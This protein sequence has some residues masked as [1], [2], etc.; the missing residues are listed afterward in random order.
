[1]RKPS[2]KGSFLTLT[3][4]EVDRLLE[5]MV[6]LP[7]RSRDFD[8]VLELY[9][10]LF[11]NQP[12]VTTIDMQ[13]FARLAKL[14]RLFEIFLP[15]LSLL[16]RDFETILA[17]RSGDKIIG[18][19]HVVP[20]GKNVWSLD[21]SVVDVKFRR[22]GVYSKLLNESLRYISERHGEQVNTSLWTTNAA[23]L[24]M[25]VRLGFKV[26]ETQILLGRENGELPSVELDKDVSI[27]GAKSSDVKEIYQIIK[28]LSPVKIR[29]YRLRP[30][31]FRDSFLSRAMSMI[32]WSR[33]E[34]WVM[35]VNG[36]ITG[37]AHAIFTSPEQTGRIESLYVHPSDRSSQLTNML[38]SEVL[39]FLAEKNVRRLLVSINIEWKETIESLERFGF[40]PIASV[41]EMTKRLK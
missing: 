23:P 11:K 39:R 36:K 24:K 15:L 19:I 22:R 13:R 1:M 34:K 7:V 41:H 12:R 30:E 27:R 2:V 40:K 18:E 4:A 26:I 32:T 29:A 8:G 9:S 16:R 21:S 20:H 33:S 38:L 35:E 17:A 37:Y 3:E 25:T 28:T 31:G 14:Y 5:K 6:V 10:E